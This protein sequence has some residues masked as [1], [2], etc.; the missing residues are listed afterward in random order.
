M[1]KLLNEDK[2]LTSLII[3]RTILLMKILKTYEKK[4]DFDEPALLL[5]IQKQ[6]VII[7]Q[8]KMNLIYK[9][10]LGSKWKIMI[11]FYILCKNKNF[12]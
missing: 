7:G 5:L 10:K 12:P 11:L 6:K 2:N 3:P 8:K 4:I 9:I 1:K